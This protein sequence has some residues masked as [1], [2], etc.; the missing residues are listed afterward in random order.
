MV[1]PMNWFDI[2]LCAIV[3]MAVDLRDA[4]CGGERRGFMSVVVM[5]G[6]GSRDEG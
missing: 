1:R 3:P 2:V 6:E 5:G 4:L